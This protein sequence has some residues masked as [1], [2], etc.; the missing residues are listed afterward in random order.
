MTRRTDPSA[1]RLPI[2]A[3][4]PDNHV[5]YRRL[6]FRGYVL[7][8]RVTAL[9]MLLAVLSPFA[10]PR[11]IRGIHRWFANVAMDVNAL[12]TAAHALRLRM[13]AERTARPALAETR[14]PAEMQNPWL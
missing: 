4:D 10:P 3:L 6:L 2:G 8:V 1:P 7:Y 13:A 5:A 12:N 14:M 11:I 9:Q